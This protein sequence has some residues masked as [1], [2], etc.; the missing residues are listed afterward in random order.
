MFII[1]LALYA[2]SASDIESER[3]RR[4]RESRGVLR[5]KYLP[6]VPDLKEEHQVK[7]LPN[8]MLAEE[9]YLVNLVRNL[10]KDYIKAEDCINL[11][12]LP[13]TD[14]PANSSA[15]KLVREAQSQEYDSQ[16]DSGDEIF[17]DCWT[18]ATGPLPAK[19]RMIRALDGLT[20]TTGTVASSLVQALNRG[21]DCTQ[22]STTWNGLWITYPLWLISAMTIFPRT[23][24]LLMKTCMTEAFLAAQKGVQ[25][26]IIANN[27]N[28]TRSNW[29][30]P[31]LLA[32]NNYCTR[33]KRAV[34][35]QVQVS[36]SS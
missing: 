34:E 32:Y 5:R 28:F 14:D 13:M 26:A 6:A 11:F 16:N 10:L 31:I 17:N 30:T 8:V 18:I 4:L 1:S 3:V 15:S 2:S 29:I 24:A 22:F 27:I 36:A 21:K 19:P 25:R 35:S 20:A 7:F 12:A 23:L 33:E 9:A